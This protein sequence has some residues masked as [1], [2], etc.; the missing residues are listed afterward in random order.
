MDSVDALSVDDRGCL[1]VN[2]ATELAACD[3]EVGE[4][5]RGAFTEI[6]DA[7]RGLL[8]RGVHAGEL[9]DDLDADAVSALLTTTILGLRV[10]GR[11]GADRAD[12]VDA[13]N[14]ALTTV[15][16]CSTSVRPVD[17]SM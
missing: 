3:P 1:M 5:V 7:V 17:P 14:A 4:R 6:R 15:A 2:S 16:A 13:V 9:A 12:L 8:A 11:A 10:Q